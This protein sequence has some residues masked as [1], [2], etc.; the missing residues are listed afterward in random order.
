[1]WRA[2]VLLLASI[3]AFIHQSS[4][5]AVALRKLQ[6][7]AGFY[8]YPICADTPAGYWCEC[9]T[10]FEWNSNICM[11]ES[12]DSRLDFRRDLSSYAII[13]GKNMP[14]FEAFTVTAWINVDQNVTRHEPTLMAYSVGM[15]NQFH[16][17]IGN[18]F[19]IGIGGNRPQRARNWGL[20]VGR[21]VHVAVTW[22]RDGSWTLY[23]NGIRR[24]GNNQL[25][26]ADHLKA[27]GDLTIGHMIHHLTNHSLGFLGQLSHVHLW[28]EI[29]NVTY[30][31]T[32]ANDCTFTYCGNVAEWVDF[33][34]G[35]RGTS[36]LRWPSGVFDECLVNK[37]EACD[38]HCS[39]TNG[40]QC[41]QEYAKNILW[42]RT[43]TGHNSTRP[44]PG[45]SSGE[46]NRMCMQEENIGIWMETNFST[47]VSSD[48]R[49]LKEE[50]ESNI[51]DLNILTYLERLYN[52]TSS[53]K[54]NPS[55]LSTSITCLQLIVDAQARA[56][57]SYK[58][59][60]N[61]LKF[62]KNA[63]RP[64]YPWIE[65]TNKFVRWVT[66]TVDNIID[67]RNDVAWN[68]TLPRGAQAVELLNVMEKFV[69]LFARSFL[70]HIKRGDITEEEGQKAFDRQ[71]IA[72]YVETVRPSEFAGSF[73]PDITKRSM[74]SMNPEE[75]RALIP[76]TL[77]D[78]LHTDLQET[79]MAVFYVRYEKIARYLP[80]HPEQVI[81]KYYRDKEKEHRHKDDNVNSVVITT[82]VFAEIDVHD[83]FANLT[84]PVE[85]NFKFTDSFNIS[86]PECVAID[87][88]GGSNNWRWRL[89]ELTNI[90]EG[91]F[92]TCF[93][94]QLGTFAVT[95]DMYNIN[96][97][98]GDPPRFVMTAAGY[99][100]ILVLITM[101]IISLSV[102]FYL[103]CTTD[104]VAVHRNL[105]VSLIVLHLLF[106]IGIT[107]Q[108][109]ATVCKIFAI[110]IHFFFTTSFCW[111]CNEAFNLYIEV[112]NSIHADTQQQRPMLRYYVIGWFVPAVLV[113]SL[114]Q[115]KWE[116]YFS[117]DV[118]FINFDHIWL[119]A[120]PAGG[121]W[122]ITVFVLVYTGKDIMESS[123]SKDKEANKVISN[124]CKGCWI[125]VVL[126]AIAWAFAII[127]VDLYSIIPQILFAMF[128][129]LQGAF[130]FVFFCTLDGEITEILAERRSS[131]G[132]NV[133]PHGLQRST[134]Y[135]VY[136]RYLPPR[137]S[138]RR[139]QAP[140]HIHSPTS[141]GS[142]PYP[143]SDRPR[144]SLELQ[145]QPRERG[146][147][148]QG[149]STDTNP[150][151][152]TGG[153]GGDRSPSLARW[154]STAVQA[155]RRQQ[156]L[157]RK[158]SDAK[159]E[160]LSRFFRDDEVRGA[161]DPPSPIPEADNT[162]ADEEDRL[163]TSV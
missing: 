105:A 95:T 22:D 114:V 66:D 27:G 85:V 13:L 133:S 40:P 6:C 88:S 18:D 30:I 17:S 31:R 10:G 119:F 163:V 154:G 121:F 78:N 50:I 9:G 89:S 152:G 104:T 67:Q 139:S 70:R 146:G 3:S 5:F 118:C 38:S 96:W 77:F 7:N 94:D 107:R 8:K 47:C 100:G 148:W 130:F 57:S 93:Y 82:G 79:R 159:R 91:E 160:V 145:S 149:G 126:M 132:F 76:E 60:D 131:M 162:N 81:V 140:S 90:S 64:A 24:G 111:I 33:R 136:R 125:Q 41:N 1:M 56:L 46:A 55:D 109:N 37:A 73:F 44:C 106:M 21:W 123:Y 25:P 153:G 103:R 45:I 127:S 128:A 137:T 115:S 62:N 71:N 15:E 141:H 142:N 99:I 35:T 63:R 16:I 4:A 143:P 23:K 117:P 92:A 157:A 29:L 98:P 134:K 158:D 59:T 155:L 144:E 86:N 11:T 32:I 87:I 19:I 58:W 138:S 68:A 28:N 54:T 49:D 83:A 156:H 74:S 151:V 124:H 20:E 26:I 51:S 150:G 101:L 48:L 110:S 43:P 53:K 129:I 61:M 69:N 72:I 52:S 97:D 116:T 122:A 112:A 161:L 12:V 39:E 14:L 42:P 147:S 113:F 65:E 34:S 36:K 135:S 80:N 108:E 120:G 84:D 2:I 75:G 102:F